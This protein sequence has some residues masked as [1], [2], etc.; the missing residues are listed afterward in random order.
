MR[1]SIEKKARVITIYLNERLHFRAQRF[2]ILQQL[3]EQ[4][5]ILASDR[6]MRNIINIFQ[7]E[8]YNL[9]I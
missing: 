4:E 8:G 9:I 5:N 6:T 1:L 3:A 2:R 7:E